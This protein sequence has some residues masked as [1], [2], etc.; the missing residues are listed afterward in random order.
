MLPERTCIPSHK[1]PS[2]V[3]VPEGIVK[4][5]QNNSREEWVLTQK[6]L[7][8]GY[9]CIAEE[10]QRVTPLHTHTHVRVLHV[11]I[12]TCMHKTQEQR[13]VLTD[14]QV[15]SVTGFYSHIIVISQSYQCLQQS[16]VL[17][18]YIQEFENTSRRQIESQN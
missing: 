18:N 13:H 16:R 7:Q 5:T 8:G 10:I 4:V 2:Y 11:Y 9:M 17:H 15:S 6:S 14:W 3:L 1:N 12:C